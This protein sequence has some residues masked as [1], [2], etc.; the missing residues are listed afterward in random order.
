MTI[1]FKQG[2]LKQPVFQPRV[3]YFDAEDKVYLERNGSYQKSGH[4]EQPSCMRL[5]EAFHHGKKIRQR[6]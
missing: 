1:D 2:P 3:V 6:I 5:Q 4:T